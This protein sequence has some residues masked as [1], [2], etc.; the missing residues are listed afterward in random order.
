M[1]DGERLVWAASYAVALELTGDATTAVR[2]ATRSIE[3][4][5]EVAGHKKPTTSEADEQAFVDEIVSAP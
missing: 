5:R 3:R 4:L 1:T 2:S